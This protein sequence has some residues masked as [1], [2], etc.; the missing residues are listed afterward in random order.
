MKRIL[1]LALVLGLARFAGAT[2]VYQNCSAASM[3]TNPPASGSL[4]LS[5][6]AGFQTGVNFVTPAVGPS[7]ADSV[8]FIA[9]LS[10]YRIFLGGPG[11][12]SADFGHVVNGIGAISNFNNLGSSCLGFTTNDG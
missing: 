3:A 5:T 4:P 12:G 8:N 1:L 2:T 11:G 7:A 10:D 6:C 9:L